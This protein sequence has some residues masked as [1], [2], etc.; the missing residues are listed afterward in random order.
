[1]SLKH[2]SILGSTG[3]IGTQTLEVIEQ[4]PNK[5]KVVSLAAATNIELLQKQVEKHRPK[6]VSVIDKKHAMELSSKLKTKGV[7]VTYG[8][9]GH[10]EVV[11]LDCIDLVVSAMVGASG[12]KPTI[13]AIKQGKNIA[14]ANKESLVI[15]GEI[16]IKEAASK[17]TIIP[18]DSEH[19]A[20]FQSLHS[21]HHKH[22]SRL[23]ITASGGPFR[24]LSKKDL[25]TV[26]VEEALKHPTWKMGKKI[27]ID[28]ATL[29]N[30]GFE[31]I[32][33]K[34]LFNIPLERID[35]WIHPQSIVHSMVEYTDGSIVSQLSL[36]DMKVPIAYALAYPE[37]LN[38]SIHKIKPADISGLTFEEIQQ[39]KFNAI[40]LAK[41]ACG[42]GGT[43]PAVLNAANEIAVTAF[44]EKKIR[45]TE[46]MSIVEKT[47]EAHSPFDISCIDDVMSADSW[48]RSYASSLINQRHKI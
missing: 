36:P 46:I 44:L 30:K 13:T 31:I 23:I 47:M 3:S 20:I 37:R 6:V 10:E 18:I 28:S 41:T 4:F 11:S 12:L 25:E 7:K 17:S 16:L 14:I 26:T 45:F 43:M 34:W 29:M 33:A 1:M 48:A 5:F 38:M 40:E 27:T 2:I 19:S 32:E 9:K 15:A 24:K 21:N 8:E 39:D 35:I 22:V 42:I